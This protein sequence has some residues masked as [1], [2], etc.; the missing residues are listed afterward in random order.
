M[1]SNIQAKSVNST[2]N[3]FAIFFLFWVA[4]HLYFEVIFKHFLSVFKKQNMGALYIL[5]E[6]ESVSYFTSCKATSYISMMYDG[7]PF[8]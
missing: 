6:K 7:T 3:Q 8:E 5:Q 1:T 2:S 4:K